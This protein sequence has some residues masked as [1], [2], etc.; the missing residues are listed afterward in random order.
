MP[1]LENLR[2]QAKLILRWHRDRYYPVAAQIRSG[3]PRFGQM[4]DPEI[5]SHSFKLSD[6]Q[7]LVARQHGF[8]SWQALK[9]GLPTM[10]DHADTT[11]TATYITAAEPQLF[12]ADIKTSCDFFTG[13]L[14]FSVDF[15]Y[16]EPPF[17]A[18]VVRDAARINLR[19]V[20]AP[21]IDPELRD[22][23]ELLAASLTVA[24]AEEIKN[25]FLAFQSAGVTF[26]QTLMRQPWG[27]RNFIVK[28]PDG[29]LLLF[30]GPAE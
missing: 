12:V 7:E 27:A 22:R 9:T 18:Q 11:S 2:K 16:G 30:A 21:L 19:C 13:K 17:Y 26:F 8:A 5:L 20:A 6:A 25:L 4:T 24:S 23:E 14:G 28:D 1:N 29:N 15:I 10:P 3:L